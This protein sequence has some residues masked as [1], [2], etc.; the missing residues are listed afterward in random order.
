M[1]NPQVTIAPS[2]CSRVNTRTGGTSRISR[3]IAA[4]VPS[5]AASPPMQ[6]VSLMN[7]PPGLS[8]W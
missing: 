2:S 5:Q 4:R 3:P 6:A 7:T 1:A 8:N